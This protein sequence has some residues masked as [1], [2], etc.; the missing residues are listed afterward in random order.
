MRFRPILAFLLAIALVAFGAVKADAAGLPDSDKAKAAN[1]CQ[2]ILERTGAVV[3]VEKLNA[4]QDCVGPILK[5]VQTKPGDAKCLDDARDTCEEQLDLAAAKE[6]R[7]VEAVARKCASHLTVEELLD[8]LGLNFASLKDECKKEFGVEV[9][10]IE[11]LGVCL[12]LQHSCELERMFAFEVPRAASLL[13]LVGVDAARRAELPCLTPYGGSDGHVEYPRGVG[14]QVNRCARTIKTS[15]RK[16][17]QASLNALGR[18][19]DTTFTC[20]QVKTDPSQL[21]GC[22]KKARN[23]C[24]AT[25]AK[26][27]S[28]SGRMGPALQKTCGNVDFNVFREASGLLLEAL[29][30][31]CK[32]LGGTDPTTLA[33]YADC[34]VRSHR[35]GVAELSRFKSPRAEELLA[36]VGRSLD[37]VCDLLTPIPGTTVTATTTPTATPTATPTP[38]AT[39]TPC[40]DSFEPNTF[41]VGKSLNG[42]C[43]HSHCTDDGYE[44]DVAATINS[45]TDNDFYVW[46]VADQ[47]NDNFQIIAQLKDVPKGVNLDLYLYRRNGDVF[48]EVDASTNDGSANETVRYDG[49][50]IDGANSGQYG[51]EVRRVSGTSCNK[52][53]LR[54]QDPN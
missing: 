24:D 34:L 40:D 23:R 14:R 51:L 41:P 5:C 4:L 39:A 50:D 32:L 52:Y 43:T 31:D 21:P 45:N 16:L 54:I 44:L 36:E 42:Q 12:A 2:I 15:G 3:A 27:R 8:P 6:A 11:S 18:C 28:A 26:L 38:T 47:P 1:K 10:D 13:T 53:T 37:E 48:E 9:D 49:V 30:T 25:F 20:V 22:L 7:M 19:L 33:S 46:D 35:C 17:V 29:A